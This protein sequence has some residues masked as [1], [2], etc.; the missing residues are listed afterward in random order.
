MMTFTMVTEYR[1]TKPKVD[2][3]NFSSW[4]KH[5]KQCSDGSLDSKE[6]YSVILTSIKRGGGRFY[7]QF[8]D[9]EK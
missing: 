3:L 5:D 8:E 7:F 6:T 9:N 2:L 1:P 4:F